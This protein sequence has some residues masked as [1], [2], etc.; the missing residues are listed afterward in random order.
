MLLNKRYRRTI[1]QTDNLE[2]VQ[3]LSDMGL[4]ELGIDVLRRTQCIMKPEGQW[5]IIHIPREQNLVVD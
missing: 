5:R 2:V 4:E 1:I 3:A